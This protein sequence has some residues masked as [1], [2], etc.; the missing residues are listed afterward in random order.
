MGGM[1]Q[2][3][4]TEID[5]CSPPTPTPAA[6]SSTAARRVHPLAG[7]HQ[8]G[9]RPA[10]APGRPCATCPPDSHP[11]IDAFVA[12]G[13]WSR[14]SGTARPWSRWRWKACCGNGTSWPNGCARSGTI[15]RAPTAWSA[16]PTTGRNGNNPAWLLAGS[17][18]SE[19]GI[20]GRQTRLPR[21]ARSHPR[22]P[23]RRPQA[24]KRPHRSRPPGGAREAA[25][26]AKRT[27][28]CCGNA[29]ASCAVVLAV[30][31]VIAAVAGLLFRAGHPIAER[32]GRHARPRG[33]SRCG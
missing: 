9:Q 23:A 30:T 19:A 1:H 32:E 11:L 33:L 4:Q 8:P 18:L 21:T 12:N 15:S 3:V 10:D 27:R 20:P 14:T 29:P 17:R 5:R 7:H 6:R 31:L 13:C 25:D 28:R 22:L 16:P 24:G 2:V 26:R